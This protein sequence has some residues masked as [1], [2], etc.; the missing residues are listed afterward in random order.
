MQRE[1]LC[2]LGK[3]TPSHLPQ[4]KQGVRLPQRY[5]LYVC[6]PRSRAEQRSLMSHGPC[7]WPLQDELHSSP[8]TPPTTAGAGPVGQNRGLNCVSFLWLSREHAASS[9]RL[10]R[11]SSGAGVLEHR[12]PLGKWVCV[13]KMYG[14]T[15]SC[16]PPVNH[17]PCAQLHI[18]QLL[19]RGLLS[20]STSVWL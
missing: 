4:P 13:F 18:Q 6:D 8:Q 20:P 2:G 19:L 1:A 9:R 16:F 14:V 7:P 11:G 12:C 3:S 15:L 10:I 17:P 5:L